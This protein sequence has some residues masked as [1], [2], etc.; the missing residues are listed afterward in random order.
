MKVKGEGRTRL[1]RF[2]AITIPAAIATAGLGVAVLQGV[3]AAT[4]SSADG[5]QLASDHLATDSLKLRPGTTEAGASGNNVATAYAETGPG[6]SLNGICLG[7]SQDMPSIV[8]A[9]LPKVGLKIASSQPGIS[10]PSVAL[11][12]ASLDGSA[13]NLANVVAG[14]AQ[15]ADGF[16]TAGQTAATGYVGGGFGLTSAGADSIDGLKAKSYAVT[17]QGLNLTSGLSIKVDTSGVDSSI[18]GATGECF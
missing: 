2:A 13:A 10:T 15:S 1:T 3:V 14:Q 4:I 6:T 9:V 18:T 5:F 8:S 11:N 16:S 12:A 17:L 7:V